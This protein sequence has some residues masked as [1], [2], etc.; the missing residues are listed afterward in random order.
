MPGLPLI[1]WG[2][3]KAEPTQKPGHRTA[4]KWAILVGL[5]GESGLE[6]VEVDLEEQKDDPSTR[7]HGRRN[8]ESSQNPS[9]ATPRLCD[10]K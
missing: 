6:K 3:P 2:S 4:H 10:L 5:R 9:S 8:S 1:S 7:K